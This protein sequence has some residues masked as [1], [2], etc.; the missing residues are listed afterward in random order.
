MECNP[1]PK[2]PASEL[3]SGEDFSR[4]NETAPRL[5]RALAERAGTSVANLRK[6]ASEG[7]LTSDALLHGV[8]TERHR[9]D[10]LANAHAAAESARQAATSA[11]MAEIDAKAVAY[12]FSHEDVL[13]A[14]D[15]A[16]MPK[17]AAG[18]ML[19][20]VHK[21]E[22]IVP[23]AFNP[24]AGGSMG[25]GNLEGLVRQLLSEAVQS[26]EERRQQ[27]GEIVRLNAQ[28]ARLLQRWDGDGL[29][30]EREEVIA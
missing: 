28:I 7:R 27:A 16:G 13:R 8:S 5:I 14:L 21:N 18:D 4:L 20:M 1:I 29:P 15:A 22:A 9:N 6:M 10:V 23:A 11:R 19:A 2:D 17:F 25:G 26:R 24:W 30:H 3:L 12:G